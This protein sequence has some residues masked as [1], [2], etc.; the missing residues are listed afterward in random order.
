MDLTTLEQTLLKASQ[1][2][3]SGEGEILPDAEYDR[4]R[5]QLQELQTNSSVLQQ[6]GARVV[7]LFPE[8]R[9]S[10]PMLSLDNVFNPEELSKFLSTANETEEFIVEPKYD[11]LAIAIRYKE[12]LIDCA[13]TRGDGTNGEDVTANAL[14]ISSIPKKLNRPITIEVRGEITIPR[15]EFKEYNEI[16]KA[17]GLKP[18]VNPRN[19][20]AG[21]LR[22]KDPAIT[23]E[24]PLLFIPYSTISEVESL[25]DTQSGRLAL[26][27]ELGFNITNGSY[28][29]QQKDHVQSAVDLVAF[30]RSSYR[31]DIDGAVIKINSIQRQRELGITERV[32]KW[33]TAFK[34]PPESDLT[35]VESIDLQIGRTGILTPVARLRPVFVGGTTITNA[36]LHN[37]DQIKRLDIRVGDSVVIQRAG[38]VIPEIT[39]VLLSKRPAETKPFEYPS[40]CPF[41]KTGLIRV[42]D[43]IGI[44]CPAG[45]KCKEQ[46]KRQL[47]YFVSREALD[48]D[49]LSE[50]RIGLLVDSGLVT[51]PDEI[52]TL[53]FEQWKQA[54]RTE[55]PGLIVK[56]RVN[57]DQAV[58]KTT[59][60]QLLTALG[61]PLLGSVKARVLA[62]Q[63]PK[64]EDLLSVTLDQLLE[65]KGFGPETCQNVFDYFHNPETA[66]IFRSLI[67]VG[68]VYD[69][70]PIKEGLKFAVTGTLEISRSELLKLIESAGHQLGSLSGNTNML[71]VGKDPG[72]KVAKAKKL[73]V[74]TINYSQLLE[75]LEIT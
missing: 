25:P 57:L 70:T 28:F 41:C 47:E 39:S 10:E 73:K 36:T 44:Y 11:G 46:L 60:V 50:Q 14:M 59:P 21:S 35:V 7:G 71:I 23:A 68:F 58:R 1:A 43:N 54:L 74:P 75:L 33:A 48:I 45:T 67:A 18:L 5:Q 22:Q 72:T 16:R 38:D 12:G 31:V 69:H 13:L 8:V 30:Q 37:L 63:I 19:G 24:R 61:I 4:L 29:I 42:K 56:I 17:K 40:E 34:F 9:H 15:K 49:D 53:T 65:I 66:D 55:R 20:A 51:R 3:Y 32:P 52:F 62:R 26:L 6:V 2:Y 64:V 27:S